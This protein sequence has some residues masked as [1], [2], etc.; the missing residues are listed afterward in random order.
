[1]RLPFAVLVL[2]LAAYM[3]AGSFATR[4]GRGYSLSGTGEIV[5]RAFTHRYLCIAQHA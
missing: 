4:M 3:F 2:A 5:Y 1:L